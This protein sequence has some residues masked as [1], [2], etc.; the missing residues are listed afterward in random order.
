MRNCPFIVRKVKILFFLEDGTVQVTEPKVENSGI[1]QGTLISR[2]RIR[3][4]AP[5]DENFYDI[6]DFNVGREVELYGKV[7]KITNCDQF[8]RVFLNRLGISVPDPINSPIDP[9]MEVR[10][11]DKDEMWPK[12]PNRRMDTLAQFLK[13]DRKV[14]KNK[15]KKIKTKLKFTFADSEIL[16]L[17]G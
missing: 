2:Q 4:P 16:R 8:T 1:P 10:S 6:I 5:M 12:K 9:Y 13:N 15:K 14:S 11:H 7:F 17:L 3:F